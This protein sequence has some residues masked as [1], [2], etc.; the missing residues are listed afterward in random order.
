MRNLFVILRQEIF[1]LL[2][3]PA[4][5]IA[6][7]YFLLVMG[8]MFWFYLG[9]YHLSTGRMPPIFEL[10]FGLFIMTPT[11][12]PFLT[13]RSLA[14]ERRTGTLETL[15]ATPTP[16]YAI[17]VGKWGAAYL[18]Y[19]S[20]CGLALGFPAVTHYFFEDKVGELRF[21]DLTFLFGGGLYLMVSGAA[22]VAIGI[23]ASSLTRSQLVAGMLTFTL[24]LI[25]LSLI[26]YFHENQPAAPTSML[27]ETIHQSLGAFF[28]GYDHLREF[29]RGIIDTRPIVYYLTSAALFLGFA[30]LVTEHRSGE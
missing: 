15:L 24:L 17:V 1:S 14:E 9:S 27:G 21:M 28:R 3:S 20:L 4:T 13:M 30:T 10:A 25:Q 7:F 19:L 11:I 5:F 22:F 12:I 29:S 2:I 23:F 8:L 18:Y 26:Y 16:T 6:G